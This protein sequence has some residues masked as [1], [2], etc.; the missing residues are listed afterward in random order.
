MLFKSI[1]VPLTV[2]QEAL[3][4]GPIHV[5]DKKS[6]HR[7]APLFFGAQGAKKKAN[8]NTWASNNTCC[9]KLTDLKN[10][11]SPGSHFASGSL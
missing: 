8:S 1:G 11:E 3:W 2:P 7:V 5:V 6:G 9:Y 4:A 10:W